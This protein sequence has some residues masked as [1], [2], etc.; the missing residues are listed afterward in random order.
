MPERLRSIGVRIP[1][2]VGLAT[3]DYN[4]NRGAAAGICQS[5]ELVGER[6]VEALSLLMKTNQRGLIRL[7]NITLVDGVWR[8]GPELPPRV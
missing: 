6:A 3:L 8:D 2:D 1:N 4:P 7:P 5:H